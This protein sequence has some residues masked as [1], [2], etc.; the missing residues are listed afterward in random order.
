MKVLET[1]AGDEITRT[2]D[3]AIAE[4]KAC[5]EHCQFDF[6][7]VTVVVAGD[8]DPALIYR[9]WNRGLSGYLGKNPTVGPYPKAELSA[10][11]IASDAAISAEQDRLS[12]IQQQEYAKQGREKAT[13]LQGALSLCVV[14]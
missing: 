2:I 12:A 9:E 11:E 8:S 7:G 14:R 1:L 10:D 5:G 4:A 6:N 13:S 3:D